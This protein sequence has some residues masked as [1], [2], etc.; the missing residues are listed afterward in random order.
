MEHG[1]RERNEN[2]DRFANLCAFNKLVIGGTIF[3]HKAI[4]VSPD[5]T[6]QTPIDHICIDRKFRKTMEDVRNRRAADIASD[7]HPVLSKMKLRL[8]KHWTSG[9]TG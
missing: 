9:E 5:H 4:W 3:P 6:T 2:G 8:K 7:H 1:L